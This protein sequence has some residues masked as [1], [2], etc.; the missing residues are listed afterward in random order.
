MGYGQILKRVGSD[1]LTQS[2]LEGSAAMM[3]GRQY[4]QC[5]VLCP[6]QRALDG[7]AQKTGWYQLLQSERFWHS[8]TISPLVLC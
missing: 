4:P 7:E 2:L 5:S 8:A 3:H 6:T 1:P